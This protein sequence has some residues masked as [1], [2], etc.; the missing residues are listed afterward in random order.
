M[1]YNPVFN[2]SK[3]RQTLFQLSDTCK[4]YDSPI[5]IPIASMLEYLCAEIL[6]QVGNITYSKRK[7]RV[8]VEHIVTA[9]QD[10]SELVQMFPIGD[11]VVP[12]KTPTFHTSTRKI[13]ALVHPENGIT[14][15]A[16]RLLDRLIYDFLKIVDNEFSKYENP[17]IPT[18]VNRLCP[19]E[20]AKHANLEI[21]KA[22]EKY[23]KNK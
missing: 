3:L 20:L 14:R 9:I 17:D 6:E 19:G 5:L 2:L 11:L 7:K 4:I 12:D 13:L 23:E 21:V 1:H 16:S 10:D 18:I 8:T 22:M 15:D